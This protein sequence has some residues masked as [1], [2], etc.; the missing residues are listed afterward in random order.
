MQIAFRIDF[1]QSGSVFGVR[2]SLS[3]STLPEDWL[4]DDEDEAEDEETGAM[5]DDPVE[6]IGTKDLKFVSV[7]TGLLNRR[8]FSSVS[9]Q[10]PIERNILIRISNEMN[11]MLRIISTISLCTLSSISE[12]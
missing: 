2:T 9:I 10:K 1:W 12:V 8:L 3:C 11:M 5:A 7:I 4:K 6:L